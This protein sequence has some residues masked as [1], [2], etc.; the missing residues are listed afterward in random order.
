M[1][2]ERE[3]SIPHLESPLDQFCNPVWLGSAP[4]LGQDK[5][6]GESLSRHVYA[7]RNARST[8]EDALRKTQTRHCGSTHM[9]IYP[10]RPPM[11]ASRYA[12]GVPCCEALAKSWSM[13]V[14]PHG[15]NSCRFPNIL[16][17][18]A[19]LK[20]IER[21]FCVSVDMFFI[22]W[23]FFSFLTFLE[24]FGSGMV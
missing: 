10:Q 11:T 18:G 20:G 12:T 15:R 5:C 23:M 2:C 8:R 9:E 7:R 1:G 22:T 3:R 21:C 17:I 13:Q 14:E 4:R 19:P 6:S 16:A 24:G